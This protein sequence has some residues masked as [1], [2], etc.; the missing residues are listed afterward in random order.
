LVRQSQENRV[1]PDNQGGT[2]KVLILTLAAATAF[3]AAPPCFSP[4]NT[5]TYQATVINAPST[6]RTDADGPAGSATF[7]A[8]VPD[9]AATAT[10]QQVRS[11]DFEVA[12][13]PRDWG[14]DIRIGDV[15]PIQ[16]GR[17]S[18]DH[19]ENGYLYCAQYS[20]TNAP[21]CTVNVFRSVD[22][23][24]T[25]ARYFSIRNAAGDDTLKDAVLRVGPGANPWIYILC[26]YATSAG[27]LKLYRIRADLT[28]EAFYNIIRGDS[29]TGQIDLDR[30]IENPHSLFMTYLEERGTSQMLRLF[31]SYDSGQTWTGG[32][33]VSS[34]PVSD[35]RVCAGADGYVYLVCTRED[36][37]MVGR[38]TSNLVSPSYVFTRLDHIDGDSCFVPSVAA[39]RTQAGAG[40]SAWILNRHLHTSSSA[41]DVH[42][43]Y[44]TD[45]GTTWTTSYWTPC[46]GITHTPEDFRAPYARVSY[47]YGVDL[48]SAVATLYTSPESLVFAWSPASDPV[49]WNDRGVINEQWVTGQH[50]A[51]VDNTNATGGAVVTWREQG[52]GVL[53]SDYWY[54][55]TGIEQGAQSRPGFA[56]SA[57]PNPVRNGT[58]IRYSLGSSSRV[59]LAVYDLLGNEV[60]QLVSAE[61]AAGDYRAAWDGRDA[62]GRQLANGVYLVRLV[63]DGQQ[64]TSKLVLQR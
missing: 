4:E 18:L 21:Q 34:N 46:G 41:Y 11:S 47:D 5:P 1:H 43:S 7:D 42:V 3:A 16:G 58:A 63:A 62:E 49:T 35:P 31:A 12:A 52:T 32:R 29:V 50:S 28:N 37:I 23:G 25:W 44:T 20:P 36:T 15:A 10:R 26:H 24:V 33:Q 64:A 57:G 27:A 17:M 38:Y 54:N 48:V 9:P 2:V 40:Q 55:V 60:R 30:D 6:G 39:S 22:S 53:W 13:P 14:G 8:S 56:V 59:T 19:S 61:Q 51:G 45:G